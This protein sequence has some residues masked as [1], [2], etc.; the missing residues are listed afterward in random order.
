MEQHSE[1]N[2]YNPLISYYTRE[3][4]CF[5]NV[6]DDCLVCTQCKRKVL[7]FVEKNCEPS[8][9]Q[10]ND[11]EGS[12]SDLESSDDSDNPRLPPRI[13]SNVFIKHVLVI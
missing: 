3:H 7:A 1:S 11:D 8:V 10:D 13:S 9:M 2:P 5:Y 12:S 4:D 6:M